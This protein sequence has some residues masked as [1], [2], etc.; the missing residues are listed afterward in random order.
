MNKYIL[1]IDAGTTSSRA[2]LFD[3]NAEVV[4]IAQYEFDQI[5]PKEGWVEHD[6][7]EILNTQ[8]RAIRDVINNSKI[9]P[10]NID[11]VGITNQRETTVIW[12]KK[13]GK[14]V[15]NAIVWQDRRTASFCDD[16]KKNN[17]TELIQNKTG[18]VIDAYF[19]GTKIKWILD[20]DPKIRSQANNGELLFGTID[21]WLIWN[22][23]NG[24][25]HITDPSNASRTLLYNIKKDCW[26]DE[27]L[28]LFDIPK[29]ILP[30]V[31]DSSSISAH[32]D[33]KIFG[34][35]I[36]IS[37]IAGDQQ[38]ALFGQLCIDEGDIK[39]TYGTGCFCM[40]NTGKT[41]VKS[42]N[43]MLSTIAWRI[44]GE[45]T[46]ALEGSVF[47]A[48]ALIQWLR[49][50]LGIIKNAS[51]VENLANTVDNNGG[52]TFIPALSGLAAPYWDPYAQGTIFG[53]T[54]GTE[55]GHIARAALESIALRTRDI[56]I[57]ME[58]DAGI[59]F[60]S[61]KV[62]GGASNNNLLMQIQSDLLNTNV[63]RPKTTETTALGVAFLAGLATGFW[64]D[65]P[66]LKSLWIEDR[67]FDPNLENDSE[68]LVE[69]WDK[70]IKK[71]LRINE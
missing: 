60:S 64:K 34:A 8:L 20:S 68:Q 13:T 41:F 52:V 18:L 55:N 1:A 57:E 48:G 11:S 33:A 44:D 43:K 35:K 15:F 61:L 53:I 38:A 14:P 25:S 32:I 45:L 67:S 36:P 49:D 17:K 63:V 42:N 2:I 69:L 4:E 54:R 29:N 5:F 3:K 30:D 16:L 6:A 47:V 66:S 51:E 31:V 24:Q 58:K 28:S 39:N 21:T 12:N 19:S 46:Y 50:K 9:D 7:L 56:I 23:T 22:L 40:M 10:N 65:I 59:K 26:D 70:R 27:L 71:V 37:G 62:D